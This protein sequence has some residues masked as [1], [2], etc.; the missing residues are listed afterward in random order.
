[1]S[2]LSCTRDSEFFG[3]FKLIKG[4][5]LSHSLAEL[6]GDLSS[7]PL[8]FLALIC[9]MLS[10]KLTSSTGSIKTTTHKLIDAQLFTDCFSQL[11]YISWLCYGPRVFRLL[12]FGTSL[13]TLNNKDND[14]LRLTFP[15]R[16][17]TFPVQQFIG[18]PFM[19]F[20]TTRFTA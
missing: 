5:E 3:V 6:A 19:L 17:V 13:H 18:Q 8:R 16:L 20:T 1:M 12:I 4:W 11:D 2:N 9:A 15:Q 14:L 10:L 7:K